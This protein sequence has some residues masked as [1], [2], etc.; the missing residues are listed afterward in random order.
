[1]DGVAAMFQPVYHPFHQW[2]NGSMRCMTAIVVC[3]LVCA[4]AGASDSLDFKEAAKSKIL[5]PKGQPPL[6]AISSQGKS[7]KIVMDAPDVDPAN[8]DE[9]TTVTFSF[10]DSGTDTVS[11]AFGDDG[12]YVAGAKSVNYKLI[13]L[14]PGVGNIPGVAQKLATLEQ[15]SVKFGKGTITLSYASKYFPLYSQMFINYGFL[16][17]VRYPEGKFEQTKSVTVKATVG[18]ITTTFSNVP[19]T[20][21]YSN[22]KQKNS[23]LWVGSASGSMSVK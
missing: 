20:V 6:D 16:G 8:F 14:P 11:F 9:N 13:K 21:K 17:I 23:D 1:M 22:K 3:V 15:C 18:T 5:K 12:K 19:Y 2:R 7:F 10:T 4:V